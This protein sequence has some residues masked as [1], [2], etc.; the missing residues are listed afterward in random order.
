MSAII[1][2]FPIPRKDNLE[3]GPKMPKSWKIHVS[4][5][6]G[7]LEYHCSNKKISQDVELSNLAAESLTLVAIHMSDLDYIAEYVASLYEDEDN[8]E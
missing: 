6:D 4:E 7:H 8:E 3:E 1:I 5:T 2:P